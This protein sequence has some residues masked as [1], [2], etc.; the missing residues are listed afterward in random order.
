M[1]IHVEPAKSWKPRF[2]N[3]PPPHTQWASIG[4]ITAEMIAEYTQYEMNFVLSA[5]APETIVAVV[6]QNTRLNTKFEKS[7]F[8]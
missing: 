6:A 8:A 4:Y 3:Q 2:A 5:M 1:W 7:K